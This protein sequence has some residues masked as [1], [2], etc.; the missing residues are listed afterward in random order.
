MNEAALAMAAIAARKKMKGGKDDDHVVEAMGNAAPK[1]AKQGYNVHRRDYTPSKKNYGGSFPT[2]VDAKPD[3]KVIARAAAGEATGR[4]E[5]LKDPNAPFK[6]TL[7]C[8]YACCAGVQEKAG[9]KEEGGNP[10][11]SLPKKSTI[12]VR[13]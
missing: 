13:R 2:I 1:Q 3:L 10:F 7:T 8:P 12:R 4:R 6:V 11:A 9:K 5:R